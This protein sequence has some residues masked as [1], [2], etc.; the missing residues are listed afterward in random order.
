MI[1]TENYKTRKDG[2][3][4]IRTYSDAGMKIQRDGVVYDEAIDPEGLGRI[5]TETDTPIDTKIEEEYI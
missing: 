4:L 5:Y 1:V 3:V 2:V